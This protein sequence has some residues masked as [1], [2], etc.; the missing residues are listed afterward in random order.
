M[1]RRRDIARA[2]AALA[3]VALF[4]TPVSADAGVPMLWLV[5]PAAWMMLVPIIALEAV[6]ARRVLTTGWAESL[7][8][9]T[10]AN[11]VSTLAGIP[12]TWLAL[13]LIEFVFAML[14]NLLPDNGVV[15]SE[16]RNISAMIRATSS[17]RPRWSVNGRATAGG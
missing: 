16:R 6:V 7:K 1:M 5:W 12:L 8:V 14:L 4:P 13:L 11:V 17:G 10:V 15:S 2:G 3:V 9:S